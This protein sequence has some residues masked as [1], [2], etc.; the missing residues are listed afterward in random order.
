[1]LD[2]LDT[3]C[4]HCHLEIPPVVLNHAEKKR[5]IKCPLCQRSI[6]IDTKGEIIPWS[7]SIGDTHLFELIPK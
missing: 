5:P 7:D 1:M 2:L 4:P 6:L 3:K